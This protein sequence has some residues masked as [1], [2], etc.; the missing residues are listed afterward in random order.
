MVPVFSTADL[1][2]AAGEACQSCATQFRQFGG[3]RLFFGRIRTVQCREDNLLLRRLLESPSAGEVAVVDGGGSLD[4]ALLGDVVAGLGLRQGWAGVVI[5]G[6]VRDSVA[7]AKLD[8]GLKALG[9]NPRKSG[10]TGTGGV[11]L[12]VSFGGVTFTPGQWLYS[13]DDGLL[14]ANRALV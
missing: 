13:D 9:T 11:D 5:F 10:K 6:A 12:P 14:V 3:R 2:D 4:S 1:F 7:L 8:F